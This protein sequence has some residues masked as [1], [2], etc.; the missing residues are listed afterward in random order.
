MP[1]ISV[2]I[3]TYNSGR[4]IDACLESVLS[5]KGAD[6]EV[7]VVDNASS[8]DTLSK[9]CHRDFLVVEGKENIGFGRACNLGVSRSKGKYICL[10]NP[11]AQLADKNSLAEICRQMEKNPQWGVAGT[12][13]IS[14]DGLSESP[15]AKNYPGEK[16]VTR[17][18][19]KLPG[20]ISWVIGASMIIR[21]DVFAELEGFDSDYF[22]YSEE[23][24]LCLRARELGHEIGWMEEVTVSHIGGDS[25][26]EADPY[27][28]SCRKLNGLLIFRDKHY[29]RVDCILLAK[30]DLR[31][32]FFRMIS[33]QILATFRG[34]GSKQ[35]AKARE[36]RGVWETSRRYLAKNCKNL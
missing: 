18:F 15:P 8:D 27:H 36:Y 32:A 6:F 17:D 21:Q 1:E 33:N 3:V 30:R 10:L 24:D 25:E 19:S 26:R 22:L 11:D 34:K 28:T 31:R 35:W 5:Q 23:T 9:V 29:P 20:N 14:N 4:C 12:K 2:I 16:Y 13:V 7:I